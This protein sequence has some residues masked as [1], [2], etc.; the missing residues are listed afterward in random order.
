PIMTESAKAKAHCG[1]YYPVNTSPSGNQRTYEG[2]A[3]TNQSR[4]RGRNSLILQRVKF[5]GVDIGWITRRLWL[6][7]IEVSERGCAGPTQNSRALGRSMEKGDVIAV[8]GK[9]EAGFITQVRQSAPCPGSQHNFGCAQAAGGNNYFVRRHRSRVGSRR[10]V[11]IPL[12]I[13]NLVA[14]VL[15]GPNRI[16]L[17]QRV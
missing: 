10:I 17:G 9:S 2:L 4:Q 16:N 1:D 3:H 6:S 12:Q 5:C 14:T 8:S 11:L 15:E 13:T 7:R